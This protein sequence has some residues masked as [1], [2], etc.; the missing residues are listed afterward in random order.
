MLIK[1][2]KKV[3]QK[4][5]KKVVRKIQKVTQKIQKNIKNNQKSDTKNR[6]KKS[7]LIFKFG[8]ILRIIDKFG[9]NLAKN[10]L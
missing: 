8:H 9:L 3:T 1:K 10:E 4:I 5:I 7:P 6:E 2:Y